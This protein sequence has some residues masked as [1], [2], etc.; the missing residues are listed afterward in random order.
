MCAPH[1][2]T[3]RRVYLLRAK[4]AATRRIKY[5]LKVFSVSH[6]RSK[7]WKKREERKD[8]CADRAIGLSHC[9]SFVFQRKRVHWLL[10][11][12]NHGGGKKKIQFSSGNALFHSCYMKGIA[13]GCKI[14]AVGCFSVCA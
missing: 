3:K 7:K 11:I 10:T 12:K 4:A 6:N 8:V 13:K 1:L 14:W 2:K 9:T 5:H